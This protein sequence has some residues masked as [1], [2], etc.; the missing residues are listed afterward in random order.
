MKQVNPE[1]R[2]QG[3]V[4]SCWVLTQIP[5]E[6]EED[7]HYLNKRPRL[8]VSLVLQEFRKLQHK[9]KEALSLKTTALPPQSSPHSLTCSNP[10]SHTYC[11]QTQ[12]LPHSWCGVA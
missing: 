8:E 9:H 10:G 2:N 5:A 1:G 11:S 6:A 7:H 4:K 3:T 12:A